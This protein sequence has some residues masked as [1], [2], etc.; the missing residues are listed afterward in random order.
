[1]ISTH[2]FSAYR[3]DSNH[4]AQEVKQILKSFFR[5]TLRSIDIEFMRC[6]DFQRLVNASQSGRD[7]SFLLELPEQDSSR[8]LRFLR[9]SKAQFRQDLF[10]LS[11]CD[12]KRNG[13]FVEFGATDGIELSNSYLLEKEFGWDGILAEP[14]RY[15]H[16]KLNDNRNCHIDTNCVWKD[17][18]FTLKFN[19]VSEPVLSTISSYSSADFHKKTR[20]NGKAYDVKTISLIDLLDKYNAP[21]RIDYLS[22]DTE[23][24]EYEILSNFDFNRYQFQIITCEHNFT[25]VREKIFSLLT[26]MGYKRK[27]EKIS[28]ADDWYVI[29]K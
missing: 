29:A 4:E 15:W 22:I 3:L 27:Y 19:E 14:A 8:L 24:S 18:N 20:E 25:P 7:I 17:T 21:K 13:F 6:G 23:G 1:M 9:E 16:Q 2:G 12:L 5:R 11:E 26:E 28:G 10:V